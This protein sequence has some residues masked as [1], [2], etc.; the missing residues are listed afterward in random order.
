VQ[1]LFGQVRKGLQQGEGR[2][3]A[4]DGGRL[5]QAFLL[6]RQ[7]IDARRQ[8]G[9]DRRRYLQAVEGFYQDIGTRRPNQHA[10]L[11]QRAYAFLQKEGI[12]LGTLD[13][14]LLEWC[15]AGIVPQQRQQ[16]VCRTCRGGSGSRR[17]CV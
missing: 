10:D 1:R 7:A 17:S 14:E 5:E 4:N 16:D 11:Y 15:Q 2:F 3:G 12:A 9:L 6:R 13:Q 8:D